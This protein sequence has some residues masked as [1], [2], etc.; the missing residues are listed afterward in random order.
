VPTVFMYYREEADTAQ[1]AL[2][3]AIVD[4][5]QSALDFDERSRLFIHPDEMVGLDR[6]DLLSEIDRHDIALFIIDHSWNT[7]DFMTTTDERLRAVIAHALRRKKII[8]PIVLE[9][10]AHLNP[11]QWP[12]DVR[13]FIQKQPLVVDSVD[14]VKQ[15]LLPAIK[16]RQRTKRTWNATRWLAIVITTVTVLGAVVEILGV[17]LVDIWNEFTSSP[18]GIG[19][20]PIMSDTPLPIATVT[21]TRTPIPR[22]THTPRPIA[23][24]TDTRTP[25]PTRTP[26]P[27]DT[28]TPRPIATVTDTRTP[29]DVP[30][31]DMGAYRIE[32][33]AI[34][35]SATAEEAAN[36]CRNQGMRLPTRDEWVRA[37]GQPTFNPELNVEEWVR[38]D[39]GGIIFYRVL[40]KRQTDGT[41]VTVPIAERTTDNLVF[42]CVRDL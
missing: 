14:D 18:T 41:W 28:H 3:S 5:L 39:L 34:E 31:I 6:D 42:R 11:D 21:D 2:I 17:G 24:V 32:I 36:A 4:R 30:T 22:D 26:I 15:D 19:S 33:A 13:R 25:F 16:R 38:E 23:T 1:L 35:S 27:R 20:V 37:L 9:G 40:T 7:L 29:D 10:T 12:E 8:I